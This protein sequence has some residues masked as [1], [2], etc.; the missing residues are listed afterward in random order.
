MQFFFRLRITRT[1]NAHFL[2]HSFSHICQH[3]LCFVEI[4][5]HERKLIEV[6]VEEQRRVKFFSTV[7]R[8]FVYTLTLLHH[9]VLGVRQSTYS[10]GV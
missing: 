6:E 7:N 9:T 8:C 1:R 2:F 5:E 4:C 10:L 3:W